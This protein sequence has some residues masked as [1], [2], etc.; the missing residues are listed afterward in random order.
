MRIEANGHQINYRDDG[1][2]GAPA[3]VFAHGLGTDLSLWDDVFEA[4]PDGLRLIRYDL[5]GHGESS[6]APAPYSMGQL[7]RDAEALLD[8]LEVRDA[9]FV[10][11]SLGGMIA[12]GLAIKRLDQ[13]RA[14][15]LSNTAARI[16]IKSQWD[17]RIAQARNDGMES[18]VAPALERWFAPGFRKTAAAARIGRT[19]ATT[20]TEGYA[21]CAAAIAGT[22]FYTPTSG[23][24][25]A[26]LG[27]AGSF[28]AATP[29]DL[30]R[31]TVSLIPGSRL[32]L[33]KRSGHLPCVDAPR[34][35]AEVL[36]TFLTEIGHV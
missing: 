24:R 14:L 35:Y 10:G 11:V 16:G 1:P 7:V 32:H 15:V 22:D 25:L 6:V 8:A 30:V 29:P 26:C 13:I 5:R 31:E 20:D 19:L 21:G 27:I 17:A 28:D 23:L 33:M 4:L 12:Q 34:D 18:L 36:T 2:K 3:V 9:V